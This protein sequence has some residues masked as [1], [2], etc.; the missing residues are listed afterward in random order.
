MNIHEVERIVGLSK[1][2]IRFYES[3]GLI[4]PSRNQENDYRIYTE[5][6][7]KKLKIIK[8]LRELDVSIKEL[9]DLSNNK[10]SLTECM[11]ERIKKIE[12]EEQNYS[13]IKNMC[14]DIINRHEN[15]NS[16]DITK[17]FQNIRV[18]N[19]EGFTMRN[20]KTNK[21]KKIIGAIISS[22]VFLMFF[23]SLIGVISYFQFTE[24]DAIPLP[25]YLFLIMLLGIP[26]ISMLYN[27]LIRIK[28]IIG[29]EEDEASKY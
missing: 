14:N 26:F 11:E 10:I 28:E 1:K 13:K 3:A 22:I 4:K 29:G 6:D 8:F 21:C 7:I 5:E 16:I 25:I 27:L 24:S 2:S 18:L 9:K 17:Y 20:V 19:K 23:G 12:A 15:Y